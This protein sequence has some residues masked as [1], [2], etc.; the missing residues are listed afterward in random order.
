MLRH[1]RYLV[2]C[3]GAM[4][5]L[6]SFLIGLEVSA[7]TAAPWIDT[8]APAFNRALKGDRLSAP[9]TSRNAGNGPAEIKTPR[10][11]PPA[12]PELPI[13]CEPVVSAIGQPPL[14]RIPGRCVS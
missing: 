10:V 3:V 2:A 5:G 9:S 7:T 12:A 4:L 13:G 6:T 11:M 14:A 8:A 1:S